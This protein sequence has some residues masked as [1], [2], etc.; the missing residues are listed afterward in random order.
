MPP[1]LITLIY[2]NTT[3][4]EKKYICTIIYTYMLDY[5]SRKNLHDHLIYVIQ[6]IGTNTR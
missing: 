5:N 2:L 4:A 6:L 3:L 1:I